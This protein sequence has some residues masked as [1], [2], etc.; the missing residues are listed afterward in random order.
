MG[1]AVNGRPVGALILCFGPGLPRAA[2]RSPWA[3]LGPAR[4]ASKRRLNLEAPV[5]PRS[6]GWASERRLDLRDAKPQRGRF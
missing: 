4:W 1:N 6:A 2:L 5:G 3:P